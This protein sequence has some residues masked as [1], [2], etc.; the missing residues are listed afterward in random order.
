MTAK[1]TAAPKRAAPAKTTKTVT[2]PKL[3]GEVQDP[4]PTADIPAEAATKVVT[5]PGELVPP[6]EREKLV[7]KDPPLSEMSD[8]DLEGRV[9]PEA[10]NRGGSPKVMRADELPMPDALGASPKEVVPHQ[11]QYAHL[12]PQ[13]AVPE[14]HPKKK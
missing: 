10:E 4:A 11:A 14:N 8:K 1:K 3:E 7:A 6:N 9:R 12:S 2:A 5:Q 13:P